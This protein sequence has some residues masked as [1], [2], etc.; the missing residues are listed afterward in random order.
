MILFISKY[1]LPLGR[2]LIEN[3]I[4]DEEGGLA[5]QKDLPT[6]PALFEN[7][8]LGDFTQ[9]FW[10]LLLLWVI[11]FYPTESA[12]LSTSSIFFRTAPSAYGS[13][14]ARS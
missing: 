3:S 9:V 6:I 2:R 11:R 5:P 1:A 13:F 10:V 7:R 8:D 14:Q 4:F 12:S